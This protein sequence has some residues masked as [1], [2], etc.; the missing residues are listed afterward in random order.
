MNILYYTKFKYNPWGN[1]A[2]KRSSQ[3]RFLLN[4]MDSEVDYINS[5]KKSKKIN[6]K[7]KVK[8]LIEGL[9]YLNC[10][11]YPLKSLN[12]IENVGMYIANKDRVI[13]SK[14]LDSTIVWEYSRH[15][16]N[17]IPYIARRNNLKLIALPHNLESLV[18]YQASFETNK[19]GINWLEE[20]L[21]IFKNVKSIFTISLEEQWL[22]YLLG[23]NSYYLP[24]YPLP[25]VKKY[26]LKFLN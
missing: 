2:E 25:E 5:K 19:Q 15:S 16:D 24:Y 14:Y 10:N 13:K 26:L 17:E 7:S 11:K 6:K 4:S 12:H 22:L 9:K 3:I 21:R 18:P 23:F 1:G 20:E 8:Y